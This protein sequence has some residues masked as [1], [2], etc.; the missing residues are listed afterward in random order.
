[1]YLWRSALRE[2][3]GFSEDSVRMDADSVVFFGQRSL[4]ALA[5]QNQQITEGSIDRSRNLTDDF[6]HICCFEARLA[7]T[8]DK[9][10]VI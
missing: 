1:M 2:G 6:L 9:D 5:L 8:I 10:H 3:R 7:S 4:D